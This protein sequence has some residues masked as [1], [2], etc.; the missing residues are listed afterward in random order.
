MD[1][2]AGFRITPPRHFRGRILSALA[3]LAAVWTATAAAPAQEIAFTDLFSA[4][5]SR[6]LLVQGDWIYGGL[7]DGGIIAWRLDDPTRTRRLTTMDGMTSNSV[8]D[9]AWSG[10]NLWAAT[11]VGLTRIGDP[12]GVQPLLRQIVNLGGL[13]VTCVAGT[14]VGGGEK[15]YYGLAEDGLGEINSGLPGAVFTTETT[16]G[17]VDDRITDL[18]FLDGELFVGTQDG[19]TRFAGNVFQDVSS[20]LNNRYI[21]CLLAGGGLLLA[22][23]QDGVALWDGG[24]GAW[25]RIGDLSGW[26]DALAVVDGEIWALRGG[27]GAEDRL[28]NWDGTQW[29]TVVLEEPLTRAIAGGQ[30]LWLTGQHRSTPENNRSGAV[31]L[32]A[33]DGGE[34]TGWISDDLR[35]TPAGA[36]AFAADGAPWIAARTGE[37]IAGLTDSGWVQIHETLSAEND[38]L[39]L[40]STGAYFFDAVGTP[41]GEVWFTQ[42]TAGALRYRP[43]LPDMDHVTAA[44]SGLTSDRI[45]RLLR[46]PDGPLLLLGDTDG[47]DVLLDPQNWRD[48][49]EWIRL[50]TG[51]PGLG[52]GNLRAAATGP[53][54][55]IWF[56]VKDVGLV[57]WDVNGSAG[58]DAP[59][60]WTDD[61]DDVWTPPLA[62]VLGSTFA[63]PSAVAVAVRPDGTAWIGGGSGVV[64]V[65]IEDIGPDRFDVEI[66]ESY[67][68]KTNP[69][70]EGLLSG[71]VRDLALDRNGDL[72]VAH[73]LGLDRIRTRQGKVSIDPFT[74]L[75]DY[76][77][78]ELGTIFSASAISGLPGGEMYRVTCDADGARLLAGGIGGAVLA[79][80]PVDV[81]AGDVM[82][83]VYVYPNPF[84]PDTDSGGMRIGGLP[85]D[86]EATVTIFDLSG[87]PVFRRAAVEPGQ[88][89]W[90]G[91][92]RLGEKVA[93]GPYLTRIEVDGRTAVR[94]LAVVRGERMGGAA[95]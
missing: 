43:G 17:L 56:T 92:N 30:T 85:A 37:G 24:T 50:P 83:G 59:L 9:I 10:S 79:D 1:S 42:F 23:T 15:V 5:D 90:D 74:S 13:D 78:R 2:A 4:R 89:V 61:S 11:E 47:G 94:T 34:R 58:P 31:F 16:E 21:R 6:V 48:P 41:E 91:L 77:S 54:D 7:S 32:A 44:N 53:R 71:S 70:W 75:D 28:W 86:G 18:A 19:I 64:R 60:T 55:R 65:E 3:A 26:I 46:H 49:A 36:A 88:E 76:L 81:S 72:W 80:I 62:S 40:F 68:A 12:G 51:S 8:T 66:L 38:S 33:R 63:F 87:Q 25:S 84:F 73:E 45:L 82:D 67:P 20:G 52:G 22:G 57:V 35:F 69:L 95:Q 29:T 14:S 27:D 93:T 39:G